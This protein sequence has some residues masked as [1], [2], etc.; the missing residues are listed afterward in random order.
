VGA[1]AVVTGD[2]ELAARFF[3]E[4]QAPGLR[5]DGM[6]AEGIEHLRRR[7]IVDACASAEAVRQ[8]REKYRAGL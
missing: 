6:P 2:E 3:D 5:R 8:L 4:E 1:G 7:Y